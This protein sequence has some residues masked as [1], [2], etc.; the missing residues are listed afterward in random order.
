MSIIENIENNNHLDL[1]PRSEAWARWCLD[2]HCSH[3]EEDMCAKHIATDAWHE[4]LEEGRLLTVEE[5]RELAPS[6]AEEFVKR[7][8]KEQGGGVCSQMTVNYLREDI[9][10]AEICELA[11]LD[12]AIVHS[13]YL[14][15]D[16]DYDDGNQPPREKDSTWRDIPR[17]SHDDGFD[18]YDYEEE[19]VDVEVEEERRQEMA[20]NAERQMEAYEEEL[21][22]KEKSD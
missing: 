6:I 16:Y 3:G 9:K 20:E 7:W 13:C 12:S 2:G 10:N 19:E 11:A 4:S 18:E 5:Y 22:E 21:L 8:L 17:R 14:C 15:E 1:E